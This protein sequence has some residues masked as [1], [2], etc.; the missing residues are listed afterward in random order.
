MKSSSLPVWR[1][2]NHNIGDTMSAWPCQDGPDLSHDKNDCTRSGSMTI[3]TH[4]L[5][6]HSRQLSHILKCLVRYRLNHHWFLFP[7]NFNRCVGHSSSGPKLGSSCI[8]IQL[9]EC[10]P[11]WGFAIAICVKALPS[12]NERNHR[13]LLWIQRWE[14]SHH[15]F[16]CQSGHGRYAHHIACAFNG[17]HD[18]HDWGRLS[19]LLF[20]DDIAGNDSHR[21]NWWPCVMWKEARMHWRCRQTFCAQKKHG[22]H[23]WPMWPRMPYFLA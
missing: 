17:R 20:Q 2:H 21:P 23:R 14:M 1:R 16:W 9:M 18:L 12:S 5:S 13:S 10:I 22:F 4:H 11:D 15:C 7:T 19:F 6:I 8:R 3:S